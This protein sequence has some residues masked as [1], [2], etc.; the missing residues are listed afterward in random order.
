MDD[1]ITNYKYFALDMHKQPKSVTLEIP[2]SLP[3]N[4]FISH[5]NTLRLEDNKGYLEFDIIKE[6]NSFHVEIVDCRTLNNGRWHGTI[7]MDALFMLI[8]KMEEKLN[9]EIPVIFGALSPVDNRSYNIEFYHNYLTV[10][11]TKINSDYIIIYDAYKCVGQN[12]YNKNRL[13]ISYSENIQSQYLVVG[14]K[15]IK[16]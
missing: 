10:K 12:E 7:L 3:Q 15:Y 4:S 14:F 11:N 9:I 13:E 6:K 1:S 5:K 16:Q 2:V 8:Q